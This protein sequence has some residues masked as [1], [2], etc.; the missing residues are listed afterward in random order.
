MRLK[1]LSLKGEKGDASIFLAMI[2]ALSVG[3]AV[4]YNMDKLNQTLKSNK[5]M[6]QKQKAETRNISGLSTAV[7]LMSYTGANPRSD[8]AA[9]L[10]Y[11]YPDP[12]L[13]D[14]QTIGTP[15]NSPNVPTWKFANMKLEV[16]SPADENLKSSDFAAYVKDNAR[17]ALSNTSIINFTK[18]VRDNPDNPLLI[19]AW[20]AEVTSNSFDSQKLVSKATIPVPAP[21]EPTCSLRSADGQENFQ[22]NSPMN[23]ELV[24][25]GLAIEAHIPDTT[26]ALLAPEGDFS[27][28]KPVD[29]KEKAN[30]VR[31][32]NNSVYTWRVTTPRPLVAV[33]GTNDVV[34]E[35]YAYLRIVDNN[36]AKGVT[37][38]FR[39]K[40]APPAFCKLWTDKATIAPGQCVNITSEAVGPVQASSLV[41]SAADPTGKPISGLSQNGA[42]GTF[43]APAVSSYS[44]GTSVPVATG[45]SYAAAVSALNT[46][47]QK[48]VYEAL[49][50]VTKNLD[51]LFEC[52]G[53]KGGKGGDDDDDDDDC[54]TSSLLGL[55]INQYNDLWSLGPAQLQ[56]LDNLDVSTFT[57][58]KTLSSDQLSALGTMKAGDFKPLLNM[59]P[60]DLATIPLLDDGTVSAQ[61]LKD[62]SSFNSKLLMAY[63]GNRLDS[64]ANASAAP[65]DYKILGS[66]TANDGTKN[67]CLV[68]VTAGSNSC[69]FFGNQYPN[70][71]ESQTVTIVSGGN[72]GSFNF[73]FAPA[74]PNWEVA[75]VAT[76]PTNVDPCPPGAR[77]YAIDIG[78][79]RTPF[80][81]VHS[82]DV[83]S[84]NPITNMRVDLGCFDANTKIRM[85]DGSDKPIKHLKDHDLV[86]N[87]LR[88]K[89]MAIKRVTPGPEKL[90]L[91]S[92]Q[93][94]DGLVRVT[95][96]HPFL[97]P[98]GLK[99]TDELRAGDRI[100]GTKGESIIQSVNEDKQAPADW[101]WNFEIATD[102]KDP[103]DHAILADGV[104]TGDLYLQEQLAQLKTKK[105]SQLKP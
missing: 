64:A 29:L 97:T 59:K 34:F 86:W 46:D 9:S 39:F 21:L 50:T 45:N 58:L 82:A 87:P 16:K 81:V 53:G 35:T 40:V 48:A 23:L 55:S 62:L 32:I 11:I 78:G 52:K 76:S 19:T 36:S 96:K 92:I 42:N 54:D 37:C 6:G 43:C 88:Q 24:V 47:Q 49:R 51:T 84:C 68:H 100:L 56:D 2:L 10:P 14:G 89:P 77:C 105:L 63:L 67:S 91:W 72:Q 71:T 103:A 99:Q 75:G 13:P 33:D 73:D 7:A 93:T 31:R 80:T 3:T 44:T 95:A 20:E 57:Y 18:P 90:P 102:S 15:R 28:H 41:M 27:L 5:I 83:A 61:V 101:V 65:V 94:A 70:Y 79:N 26:D 8:D 60:I 22:P 4:Y 104:V 85:A 66:I 38:P 12:Y 17:P 30:S 69:K 74:K 1:F 98:M 25:S